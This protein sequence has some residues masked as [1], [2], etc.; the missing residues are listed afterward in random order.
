MSSSE[1][2]AGAYG[3][4]ATRGEKVTV[5]AVQR[6]S[7]VRIGEVAAWMREHAAG[8]AGDVPGFPG[9]VG[10]DGAGRVGRGVETSS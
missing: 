3:A 9:P 8:A 1:K 4:L 7:G 6:E 10:G 5:R 2:I